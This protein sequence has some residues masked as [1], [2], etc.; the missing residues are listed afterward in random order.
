MVVDVGSGG[1]LAISG[2]FSGLGSS[3]GGFCH[4]RL[5]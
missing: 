5:I 2:G 4:L 3:A 1:L